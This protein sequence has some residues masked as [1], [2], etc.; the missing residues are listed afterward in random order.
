[1][2][3]GPPSYTR[4]TLWYCYVVIG[5]AAVC[6][7]KRPQGSDLVVHVPAGYN[8]ATSPPG[9]YVTMYFHTFRQHKYYIHS[10]EDDLRPENMFPK[11]CGRI[12]CVCVN[13]SESTILEENWTRE[14]WENRWL[15]KSGL[16]FEGSALPYNI[17]Y[18]FRTRAAV[19][20]PKRFPS[21]PPSESSQSKIMWL[22]AK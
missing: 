6:R 18:P 20:W 11:R 1:M 3:S 9:R 15:C 5:V 21:S 13:M 8:L 10:V 2:L 17:T 12:W 4:L 16:P 14:S 7:F 19:K 22:L